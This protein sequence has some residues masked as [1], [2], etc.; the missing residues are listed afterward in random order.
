MPPHTEKSALRAYY[1][2][3]LAQATATDRPSQRLATFL[4]HFSL[5]PQHLLAFYWPLADEV[6]PRPLALAALAHGAALALPRVINRQAPLLFFP[7][8]PDDDLTPDALGVPAPPAP[9]E[10]ATP[11]QPSHILVPLLAFDETGTRLGRGGGYYDRTLAQHPQAVAIGLAYQ[12]QQASSLPREAHDARLHFVL[13]EQVL[14]DCRAR[15]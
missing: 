11:I 2:T 3:L 7:Y 10:T 14:H 8:Q 15:P 12:V 9:T 4:Q 6:D 1:K 13:T 5:G